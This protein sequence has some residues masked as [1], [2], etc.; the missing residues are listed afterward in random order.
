MRHFEYSRAGDVGQAVANH[1]AS[2]NTAFLAGGTTLL[3]LM[4]IDVMRPV[5]VVDINRV[6]LKQIE[7][8]PDG[9]V[10][11]GALVSNTDLA[12]HA[13]VVAP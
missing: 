12:R 7:S 3:D 10:R 13:K 6:A 8:L 2:Q 4:K 5:A 9:R 1:A 11:I